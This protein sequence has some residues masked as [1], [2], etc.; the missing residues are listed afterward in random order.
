M[1]DT[2]H[3]GC[4]RGL[5]HLRSAAEE[6]YIPGLDSSISPPLLNQAIIVIIVNEA[7]REQMDTETE[8]D[9]EYRSSCVCDNRRG[10][11][12]AKEIR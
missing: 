7:E 4:R 3:R 10:I 1:R 11:S 9:H 2:H 12:T 5:C 8:I 6:R